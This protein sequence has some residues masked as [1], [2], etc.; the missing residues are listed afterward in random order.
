MATIHR[1]RLGAGVLLA[2]IGG[3]GGCG[4]GGANGDVSAGGLVTIVTPAIPTGTTGVSYTSQIEA[5]F[6]HPPGVFLLT[7][8]AMPPGLLLDQE[9][10]MVS[11]FP[12]Q[13]GHY[14]F[15]VGARDGADPS[16]PNG[17]DANFAEDRKSFDVV[18]DL[19]PPNILPQIPPAAQYRSSYG[20]QID[21]AGG[22][23]P[24]TF[25]K[26]GGN[27]PNGLAVLPTGLLASFPTSA[28]LSPYVFQVTVTDANGLTDTDTLSV[29]VVVL[30]LI[31]LT[32][33][34]PEAAQN[35]AYDQL[36]VLA[37]AGAGAPIVWSQ[38]AP[39]AGETLLSS[40]GMEI[41][42]DGH[43]RNAAGPPGPTAAGTFL[44]TLDVQDEALQHATRQY[45]LKVNP[46]PVLASIS[47]NRSTAVG[48]F[49]VN[50]ANFQPGA[51]LFFKPGATQVT[52][53]PTFVSAS[54]LTFP[55]APV[56]A[57]FAG[58]ITVRVQN[59]D[60][61]TYDLPNAFLYPFANL[62]F[63]TKGF[64]PSPV[65]STGL[66][67]ADISG[68]GLAE[69]IHCG[70]NGYVSNSYSSGAT[71]TAGGLRYY[72]NNGGL[73][74]TETILDSGNF[75]DCKFVDLNVD[76]KLDVIALGASQIKTWLN[77]GGGVL[78][79]GPTTTLP[80]ING[81]PYPAALAMGFLNSDLVPD[82]AF[83]VAT[84]PNANG[85]AHTMKGDGFGAFTLLTSSITNITTMNGVLTL[86]LIDINADGRMDVV[87]GNAFTD[88]TG[89][90]FRTNSTNSDGTQAATWSAS[91]NA[92]SAYSNTLG[93][94]KGNVFGDGRPAIVCLRSQDATDGGQ[95]HVILF[96]GAGLAT[97]QTL[98]APSGLVKCVGFADFDLDGKADFAV[99]YNTS[100]IQIY[101][102]STLLGV[103]ALDATV[104]SPAISSAR[105][106]RVATGDLDGDGRTDVLAAT[107]YWATDYQPY[108]YSGSYSLSLV[109][110]GNGMGIVFYLNSS[111]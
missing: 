111:N 4:G 64:I 97:A 31:I 15:E 94:E 96:S 84:Y 103:Q 18:I 28:G 82:L 65:S 90:Y 54:A 23:K 19:G 101:R 107:S 52:V 2:V 29:D 41:T 61:G 88:G 34:F 67:C 48:P 108:L 77:S 8:G 55:T 80:G 25:A 99:T 16:L 70:A 30:P 93:I 83:G 43:L 76:G 20:Y 57:A 81:S 17:R 33:T 37:S 1:S 74:F 14:H 91:I 69:I 56:S 102:A 44:F 26:T 89:A 12:R 109:G 95:K 51:K 53:N 59:P 32:S 10:G 104:G 9:S 11:G 105:T 106:G 6:V 39:V 86:T 98:T 5:T 22:T 42:N 13:T 100:G 47:P 46:G 79:A 3:A 24:Y 62:S 36:L 63:G 7:G 66:D 60:G 92:P 110:N 85:Q 50:G 78:A 75:Y 87:A 45:S 72:K 68:D 27:L 73:S 35:F 58:A 71:S 49:Q 38:T 21:V 40:I